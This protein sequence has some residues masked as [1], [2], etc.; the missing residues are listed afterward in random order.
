MIGIVPTLELLTMLMTAY[1]GW[2]PEKD[3]LAMIRAM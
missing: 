3:V 2:W 1:I